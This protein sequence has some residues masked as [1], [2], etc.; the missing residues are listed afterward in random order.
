MTTRRSF[1]KPFLAMSSLGFV[2]IL[3]LIPVTQRAAELVRGLPEAS[4]L[5]T[6]VLAAL[7]LVQ[8]TIL[9][10][11]GVALGVALTEK[12]GLSSFILRRLRGEPAQ[13]SRGAWGSTLLLTL[14]LASATIAADLVF[15]S[16]FP[17]AFVSITRLDDV[18]LSER[19]LG[20]LYGGITEEL[21]FRF[22]LLSLLLWAGLRLT[23]GR[24]RPFLVWIS[25]GVSALAFAAGHL[26]VV[27]GTSP[28]DQG[29][30]IARTLSLNGLLGLLFGWLY[31]RRSLE[32]AMLAHA[33]VHVIFW[34]VTPL[35]ARLGHNL[36]Q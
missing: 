30:L 19:M 23:A 7:L 8:P 22:G 33:F 26:G 27:A 36:A 18:T 15:R 11:A 9:L 25:I 10:L 17:A 16:L 4:D 21:M 3:S 5:P 35:F 6:S 24:F 34:T 14:V 28:A 29:V 31:A 20:L 12:A 2:G 32:H 13:A 1:L